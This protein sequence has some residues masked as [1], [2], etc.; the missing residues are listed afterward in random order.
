MAVVVALPPLVLMVNDTKGL[1]TSW[2]NFCGGSIFLTKPYFSILSMT[3]TN[4][5]AIWFCGD[6]YINMPLYRMLRAK[7]VKHVKGGKQ[8]LKNMKSL[9]KQLIKPA[10]IANIHDLVVQNWSLRKVMDL[11]LGVRHFF[12]FP[13][14]SIHNS[15]KMRSYETISW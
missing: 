5:L 12:D 2:G 13:C 3:F 4:M 11:Y 14:L 15:D 1:K 7:D 8:K 6:I 10:G 9:V